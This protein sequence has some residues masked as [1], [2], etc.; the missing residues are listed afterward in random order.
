MLA[1][2]DQASK[3]RRAGRGG[4]TELIHMNPEE[5]LAVEA[6]FGRKLRRNP[7]TGLR[8]AAPITG[9]LADRQAN[10]QAQP[11]YG[12]FAQAYN[13]FMPSG[14]YSD[15][16]AAINPIAAKYPGYSR[17]IGNFAGQSIA[18]QQMLRSGPSSPFGISEFPKETGQVAA[19][20]GKAGMIVGGA[21]AGGAA[22]GLGEAFTGAGAVGATTEGAGTGA[23]AAGGGVNYLTGEG[24]Q[25]GFGASTGYST[26]PGAFDTLG[27]AGIPAA[28]VG[29]ASTFTDPA[30]A[31]AF[32]LG[33]PAPAP[34]LTE[35]GS[36][37]FDLG[38]GLSVD[39][40]GNVAG[41]VFQ[42]GPGTVGSG[43]FFNPD[44][45]SGGIQD[46]WNRFK[47]LP[48]KGIGQGVNIG[49]GL[50]GLYSA[51]RMRQMAKQAQDPHVPEYQ[52]QLSKL[53]ADPSSV[54]SLPG[55]Q[56]GMDQGRLAIQRQGAATGSGGNE[57]IALARFSPEYAQRVYQNQVQNLTA[58]SRGDIS[59]VQGEAAASN[60]TN[61][62]L[63]QLGYGLTRFGG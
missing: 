49:G 3:V 16:S 4:D 10:L 51:G 17:D 15:F 39:P 21:V 33:D 56:F 6:F 38:G 43:D 52:N 42:G 36:T 25:T 12:D 9:V 1:L 7:R 31:N 46:Y 8:E 28:G 23:V 47:N 45:A 44:F 62:S 40:Y 34:G 54:T 30:A 57:A 19:N 61:Q 29:A 41:G 50:Y 5:I 22:L 48:W 58:L 27:G 53:M 18:G 14:A 37:A 11:W 32:T 35:F 63:W 60:L 55:Y 2:R 20:L 26:A 13:Q 24:V 59:A